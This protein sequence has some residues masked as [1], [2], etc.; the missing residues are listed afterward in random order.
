[1]NFLAPLKLGQALRE[2]R[3]RRNL[4]VVDIV[5]KSEALGKAVT[6]SSISELENHGKG[7]S[8]PQLIEN[9]LPAYGITDI[10]DFD[11]L[12][13]YC[14]G[15]SISTISVIRRRDVRNLHGTTETTIPPEQLGRNRA[16]ISM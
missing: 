14:V 6:A 4:R 8:Y 2:W 16:R 11:L 3:E 1:M 13:D 12:L 5:A 9:I 10:C 15:T 7:F